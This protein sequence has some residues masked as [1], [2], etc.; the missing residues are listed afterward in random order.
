[1][2]DRNGLKQ[3]EA[4]VPLANMFQYVSHLR[5]VSKGRAQYT[6][7]LKQYDFMPASVEKEITSKYTSTAIDDE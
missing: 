6:M 1:M 3:I 7:T 5:S 2:T 4:T